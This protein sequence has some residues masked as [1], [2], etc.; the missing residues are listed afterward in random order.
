ME[1]L[2]SSQ[3]IYDE[4]LQLYMNSKIDPSN[5][6]TARVMR[7]VYVAIN[8]MGAS[9]NSLKQMVQ[10]LRVHQT[11]VGENCRSTGTLRNIAVSLSTSMHNR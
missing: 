9:I 11:V 8:G 6:V 5:V 4:D 1:R 2:K 10:L 7:S 3:R